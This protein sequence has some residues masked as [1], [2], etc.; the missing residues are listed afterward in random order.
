MN[1]VNL[2]TYCGKVNIFLFGGNKREK[3]RHK[4]DVLNFQSFEGK[5][6]LLEKD[7]K[8]TE[9]INFRFFM[10]K[11]LLQL[12]YYSTSTFLGSIIHTLYIMA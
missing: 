2:T 9:H 4:Q 10:L 6:I 11:S 3:T 12:S 1:I 8:L 5:K 7:R